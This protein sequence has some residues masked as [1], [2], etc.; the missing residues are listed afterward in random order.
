V[1]GEQRSMHVKT[2][3]HREEREVFDILLLLSNIVYITKETNT[4]RREE[5]PEE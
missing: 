3:C 4:E 1:V 2:T 5:E